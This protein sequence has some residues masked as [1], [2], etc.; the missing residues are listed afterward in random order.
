M[1]LIIHTR[2]NQ[3]SFLNMAQVLLNKLAPTQIEQKCLTSK[4]IYELWMTEV[5]VQ[6]DGCQVSSSSTVDHFFT[7]R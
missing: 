6:Q 2:I 1:L 7:F 3:V 5:I 4:P